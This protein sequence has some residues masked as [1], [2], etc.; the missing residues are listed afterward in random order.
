MNKFNKSELLLA[1]LFV[2]S[3]PTYGNQ[4]NWAKGFGDTGHEAG[5]IILNDK[6]GNIILGGYFRGK[7]NFNDSVAPKFLTSKGS[8]DI[9][10]NKYNAS[11]QLIWA[12]GFGGKGPDRCNNAVIDKDGNIYLV[13][14]F[15]DTVDFNSNS[16]PRVS[17]GFNDVFITK[18]S[19]QGQLLWSRQ[20]GGPLDEMGRSITITN[21]DQV[22]ITGTFQGTAVFA[23]TNNVLTALKN[24]DIFIANYNSNGELMWAKQ[25]GG[26]AEDI[27][28]SV[29]VGKNNQIYIT[30]TFNSDVDFD[31]G[32]GVFRLLQQGVWP[33]MF[34]LG[35]NVTGDFQ[36]VKSIVG[37]NL[38]IPYNLKV[39]QLGELVITGTFRSTVDFDPDVNQKLLTTSSQYGDAFVLKLYQTGEF[40]WVKQLGG[41][42]NEI[43][44]GLEI[45]ELNNIYTTGC[46]QNNADFDP[47]VGEYIIHTR[48]NS[49]N[50]DIY[51]SKLNS[52][53]EFV[54][55]S[56]MN[57]LSEDIG[58][59]I[60]VQ[61][62]NLVYTTGIFSDELNVNPGPDS[63]F[64]QS[65]G[66]TDIFIHSYR[67]VTSDVKELGDNNI[68]NIYPNPIKNYLTVEYEV[69]DF[70]KTK[71]SIIPISSI[72]LAEMSFT[73]SSIKGRNI[74]VFPTDNI[75]TG[76][77]YILQLT[78]GGKKSNRK[79]IVTK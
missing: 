54:W 61:A 13:G 6:H 22:I 5:N 35:L 29:S 71:I 24:A 60:C 69:D 73:I 34:V 26:L 12:L 49:S 10:I 53:G 9:F 77:L 7:V 64:I 23:E 43:G 38:I 33:N 56:T 40:K 46:Y 44:L 25:V 4:F 66:F 62:S 75:L 55:V 31:P 57:G 19:A 79:F 42:L 78:S 8:E 68:I 39:D 37:D 11:G 17:A 18:I 32:V 3:I 14:N 72:E 45:D 16:N 36:W 21:D 20:F 48:G 47:G 59:S 58:F 41:E 28:Y 74:F 50:N 65:N 1:I 76:G 27:A 51:I 15:R 67:Q 2:L 70:E 52:D 30:G 63:I